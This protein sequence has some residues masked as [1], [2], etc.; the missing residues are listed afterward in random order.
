MVVDR[1]GSMASI[2]IEAE[3]GINAF[4]G[5]QKAGTDKVTFSLYEFDNEVD[6]VQSCDISEAR[7]YILKPRGMTSLCDAVCS[8]IAETQAHIKNLNNMQRPKLV[9]MIVVTDGQENN[10]KKYNMSQMTSMLKESGFEVTFL[11]ND[12]TLSRI[13]AAAG[14]DSHSVDQGVHTQSMYAS[15]SSKVTRM[16]SQQ[17]AG[18]IVLNT[19][20]APEKE[21]MG[22]FG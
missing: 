18:E 1:S 21:Q 20:S 7:P 2:K 8:A 4:I 19:Y 17:L 16:R 10:S 9:I 11:C 12:P 3:N 5:S 13:A 6:K 22:I 14:A 15:T